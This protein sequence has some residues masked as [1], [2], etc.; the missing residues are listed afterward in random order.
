MSQMNASGHQSKTQVVIFGL[1]Y[2]VIGIVSGWLAGT[3]ASA[4]VRLSWRLAAWVA[5]G[6]LLVLQIGYEHFRLRN[7]SRLIALRVA[8]AVAVGAF[9][10]AA[11][12]TVHSLITSHYR[13]AYLVALIGWPIITAVPAFLGALVVSAILRRFSR[14]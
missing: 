7:S 8:T 1:A 3:A 4:Q 12:A 6:L 11:A 5:S 9:G 13:P 14:H 10:L 2:F